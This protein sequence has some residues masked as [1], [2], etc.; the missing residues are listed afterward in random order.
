MSVK[1][2]AEAKSS[3]AKKEMYE[4]LFNEIFGTQ[5]GWSKLSLE[6]LT[7]LATVLANP[8]T[9]IKKLGGVPKEEATL[10]P[11]VEMVK[12][13]LYEYEGPIVKLIR[14]YVL[15]KREGGTE[16]EKK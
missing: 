5:I 14:R 16:E 11:F 4:K 2:V 7:Q 9:L 13:F 12:R 10:S 15:G 6:E 3:K 1:K 8:E